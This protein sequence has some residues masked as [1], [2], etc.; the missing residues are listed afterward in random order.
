MQGNPSIKTLEISF[1]LCSD[2]GTNA[3][4]RQTKRE[5]NVTLLT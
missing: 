2:L 1:P 5:E 3:K 4:L